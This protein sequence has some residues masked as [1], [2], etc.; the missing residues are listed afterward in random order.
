VGPCQ[1]D[2]VGGV[3]LVI[4]HQHAAAAIGE[5]EANRSFV[6]DAQVGGGYGRQSWG[7]IAT[8]ARSSSA[9]TSEFDHLWR[10]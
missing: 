4:E 5:H 1:G 3:G 2:C 6:L 9:A 7:E 10:G 8:S